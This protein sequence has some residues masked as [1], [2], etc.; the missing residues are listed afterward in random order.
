[1]TIERVIE[2][3][4]LGACSA[5]RRRE[6]RCATC[7][8]YDAAASYVQALHLE[9]ETLRAS[10]GSAV[11]ALREHVPD[12]DCAGPHGTPRRYACRECRIAKNLEAALTRRP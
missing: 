5:A 7:D 12:E 9:V 3:L 4:R 10:I 6:Q 1:M 11:E 8:E 2:L